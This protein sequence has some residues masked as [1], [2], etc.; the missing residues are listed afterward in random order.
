MNWA[1][2]SVVLGTG[3]M[4][5]AGATLASHTASGRAYVD[6]IMGHPKYFVVTGPPSDHPRDLPP[7]VRRL[8][9]H[10]VQIVGTGCV[11]D[12][13]QDAYDVV[14]ERHFRE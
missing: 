12:P 1:R 11:P 6:L 5:V 10:G 7:A 13:D 3:A 2:I 4:V 8:E 9:Q 14:I